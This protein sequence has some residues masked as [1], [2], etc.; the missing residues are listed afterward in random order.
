[1]D[2]LLMVV[3]EYQCALLVSSARAPNPTGLI[4][5]RRPGI[6]EC[7]RIMVHAL[8]LRHISRPGLQAGALLVVLLLTADTLFTSG[9]SWARTSASGSR[10]AATTPAQLALDVREPSGLVRNHWPITAGVPFPSGA[11]RD[12]SR[13]VISD[14]ANVST[15]LQSRVLSHWPDGSVRWALLDWQVDLQPQQERRY[16]VATGDSV[17]AGQGVQVHDL[18]DRIDVHTGPLQFSVPKDRFAWLQ[19]VRLEGT[20]IVS[21]PIAS[22]FNIDGKRVEAQVPTTVRITESGPLRVRIEIRGHYATS[23][24]YVVRVDAFAG[25]PFVRIFHTFEQHSPEPYI[26]V[27]QISAMIPLA[28]RGGAWYR[29]GQEKAVEFSGKLTADGFTL[30]QEDNETLRVGTAQR[31]GHAA[32]W[33]DVGDDKHGVAVAARFFWQQYPQSFS[34]RPNG[35]TYNLWAPEEKPARVGM[36]AAKTHEVVLYFHG[37]KPPP[38]ITLAAVT[39]PVLAWADPN[40][41]VATGALRN[42]VAPSPAADAFLG[43]LAAAYQ[44][45]QAGAA[46]E[47]WDDSGYVKCPDP[48]HER[49]RHGFFGMFNW[50]DWNYPKYHD[51]TKGCDA[52]GNLEYDM[53][54]VLALAYAATGAGAYHEG[55][56]A[57]ARHF[58]DVDHVY[59]QYQR[60]KWTG[61]NHPKNPLHFTFE[62]GGVDIGHTWTEGLLSYYYLTGDERSLDAARGIADYL[63]DRLRAG[64]RR[65]NPRQWGWPQIALVAAY[66]ATG[67]AKYRDAARAYA[68]KGMAAHAPDKIKDWKVG[69]LAEGLAYTHSVT[70]DPA[71]WQWLA[72]YAAAVGVHQASADPRFLPALAYV[73][74]VESR[75]EYTRGAT[76]GLSRLKFGN[77]GKPFT[78]AGRLGFALA[79]Q[80]RSSAPVGSPAP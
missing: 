46:K 32:G 28:L 25:Q 60:P 61:M 40:W 33:A 59:Y 51:T 5:R 69:I 80:V 44:R 57:A 12:V 10:V 9:C 50:G 2:G 64:V 45:Y 58:M 13:L 38:Q 34:L 53:T 16:R 36:G 62:L 68:Q 8:D 39:E 23:F 15:P 19:Q 52:W 47:R 24:D 37:K 66:E 72:R 41:T 74:R 70:Q 21:G 73:G 67:D 20:E 79:S 71:I 7:L 3:T 1:M 77:W 26:F 54:Q 14:D 65:G 63:V 55:M 17:A 48:A 29:A 11:V 30:V 4:P 56:V 43:E 35:I 76:A 78:I 31:P 42:S 18:A 27:R 49:P 6:N 75:M 22:A